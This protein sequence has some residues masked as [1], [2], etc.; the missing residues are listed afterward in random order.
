[1]TVRE[2]GQSKRDG[3]IGGGLRDA[4]YE[5]LGM[6][7]RRTMARSTLSREEELLGAQ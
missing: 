7:E 5:V 4:E 2:Y 1:M 3:V 6:L